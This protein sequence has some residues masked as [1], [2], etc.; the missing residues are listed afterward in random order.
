MHAYCVNVLHL[1]DAATFKRIRAA[2]AARKFPVIYEA[3]A[4]GRLHLAA[5][6]LLSPVLTKDNHR[7][8]LAAAEHKSKREVEL[9]LA[10]RF[11]KADV[12]FSLRALP[13][14]PIAVVVPSM[15]ETNDQSSSHSSQL[16]PGPVSF[17]PMAECSAHPN[18]TPPARVAPIAPKRFAIHL[19]VDQ[20]FNDLLRRAQDLASHAVPS[21]DV[22]EIL[23]RALYGMVTALEKR[24]YAETSKPG[25][26]R[27]IAEG[28]RRIPSRVRRAVW[29]RDGGR[30]TFVSGDGHRCEARDRLEFDHV[31]PF[32]LGGGRDAANIRLRCRAHNQYEAETLFG[33]EFMETMREARKLQS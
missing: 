16:A 6:V 11:P 13:S 24:K 23:K 17:E 3:L 32:A 31:R 2:R 9:L 14:K 30:C 15:F 27:E 22:G 20:E 12:P 8:L 21:R 26:A 1:S 25:P 7:E 29:R 19:T 4:G 18:T 10:E 28:S 5:I 33:A